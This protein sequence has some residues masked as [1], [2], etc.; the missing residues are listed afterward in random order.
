MH[1]VA[2]FDF[3]ITCQICL[4]LTLLNS[5]S[6]LLSP[7]SLLSFNQKYKHVLQHCP[8]TFHI[9]NIYFLQLP[10]LSTSNVAKTTVCCS[11]KF[12]GHTTMANLT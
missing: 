11:L 3:N 9:D 12:N 6:Y 4:M 1:E 8:K 5:L 2:D 10:C 7:A